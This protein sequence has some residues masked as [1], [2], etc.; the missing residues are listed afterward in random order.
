MHKYLPLNVTQAAA[1]MRMSPANLRRA[2]DRRTIPWKLRQQRR[3]TTVAWIEEGS[4]GK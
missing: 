1:M 4:R 2:M 3:Y